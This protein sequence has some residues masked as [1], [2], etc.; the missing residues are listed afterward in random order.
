[1]RNV[2]I[3]ASDSTKQKLLS[4]CVCGV[5][6]AVK[7]LF[8]SIVATGILKRLALVNAVEALAPTVEVG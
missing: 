6:A 5:H 4:V 8:T 1:M 3:T 2:K 7:T